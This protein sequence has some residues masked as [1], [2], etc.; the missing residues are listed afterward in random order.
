[1]YCFFCN[2]YN[3]QIV[4]RYYSW[5]AFQVNACEKC[6]AIYGD[7]PVK[8]CRSC[9]ATELTSSAI[10]VKDK[11]KTYLCDPCYRNQAC[12]CYLCGHRM[13]YDLKHYVGKYF[14]CGGCRDNEGYWNGVSKPI[15][16]ET[17]DIL[18]I[19]RQFGIELE[20]SSCPNF[21]SMERTWSAVHEGTETVKREFTSPPMNGDAAVRSLKSVCD[22]ARKNKWQ[23]NER[24]GLHVHV[25]VSDLKEHQLVSILAGYYYSYPY[26]CD[27]VAE[28]RV[29]NRFCRSYDNM[30]GQEL[31]SNPT[32]L[33][34]SAFGLRYYWV[35]FESLL[36]HNTIEIRNHEGTLKF[37][38]I[39]YWTLAHLTFVEWCARH[40]V[41]M[42]REHFGMTKKLGF[43]GIMGSKITRYYKNKTK[44]QTGTAP[45]PALRRETGASAQAAI[46]SMR[47]IVA[48]RPRTDMSWVFETTPIMRVDPPTNSSGTTTTTW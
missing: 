46:D 23:V 28:N 18:P 31:K 40:S 20:A 33:P 3:E 13:I 9:A 1:M 22:F 47:A 7:K 42:I 38:R 6:D 29:F 48:A 14:V 36:K 21:V 34:S 2:Q 26:W 19:K 45:R 4:S 12:K 5:C 43:D 27:M 25:D 39:Y 17:F 8:I 10:F 44:L 35:S 41:E 15:K 24:C 32:R 16:S 11:C 37:N 30:I